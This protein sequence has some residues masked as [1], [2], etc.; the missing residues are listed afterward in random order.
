MKYKVLLTASGIGSRL[1][2][3]TQYTNKSLVTIGNKP[4]I[5]Y[6]VEQY[7]KNVEF[8]VTLGYYGSHVKQFLLTAYPDR[9]FTFVEVENYDGPGSSLGYSQLCAEHELQC[10]F[11]YNACDTIVTQ[12]IPE[13]NC[14]WV[15]AK[16]GEG[17]SQYDSITVDSNG[18]IRSFHRKGYMD[19]SHVHIGLV[20]VY[21]YKDYWESLKKAYHND[22]QDRSLNDVSVIEALLT[23]HRWKIFE[24]NDWFDIGNVA[25]LKHARTTWQDK[26]NVLEKNEESISLINKK[27]IKFF[28]DKNI[29]AKRC[30]RAQWLGNIVPKI[31]SQTENFYAY[32][33]VEGDLASNA[34]TPKKIVNLLNWANTNLWTPVKYNGDFSEECMFFY[35]EKT[36]NR[37]KRF[38]AGY[39]EDS[40]HVINET[41][42]PT[43]QELLAEVPWQYIAENSK[44][45]KFHGDFILDNIIIQK[46]GNFK[47]LDWRHE[48][49]LN[50]VFAGDLYY[51]L[52]KLNHNLTVNHDIIC[53]DLFEVKV[54][55]NVVTCDILRKDNLV[56][57]NEAFAEKVKDMG[58][59]VDLVNILTGIIW[60][61]M[62]PLHHQPFD[63]FLFYYGKLKLATSLQKWSLK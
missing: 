59:N 2:N 4:A 26:L 21:D 13:P 7:P 1:G 45:T 39:K 52:A 18:D 50:S 22:R 35:K 47:L 33:Y 10:P 14:N 32:K 29:V 23:K 61:N 56:K 16:P 55:N 58:Y 46:N 3:F 42:V 41:I 40:H 19:A 17:S 43:V 20:G 30:L 11:I 15:A 24:Y 6:I 54:S 51:D 12:S 31:I 63:E 53:R 48:F 60:L 34:I 28:Y 38:L 62:A 27:I 5:S 44:P 49:G 57:C 37:V 9:K 36:T 25:A 8:V